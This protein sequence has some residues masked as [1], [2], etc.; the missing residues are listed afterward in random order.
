M[1]CAMNRNSAAVS[2]A[3][4]VAL[5]ILSPSRRRIEISSLPGRNVG[6]SELTARCSRPWGNPASADYTL[7]ASLCNLDD[8]VDHLVSLECASLLEPCVAAACCRAHEM[9][10][11]QHLW[12]NVSAMR[13]KL[14]SV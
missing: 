6:S 4:T 14:K 3:T 8:V 13:R 9:A 5:F 11:L 7:L 2:N 12:R 1:R 10:K